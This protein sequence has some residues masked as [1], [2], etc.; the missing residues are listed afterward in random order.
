MQAQPKVRFFITHRLNI[1]G[2]MFKI[3]SRTLMV[4]LLA[5]S[6][7]APVLAETNIHQAARIKPQD[8]TEA[9]IL[10]NKYNLE[11][12][13]VCAKNLADKD[14][15]ETLTKAQTNEFAYRQ[16][17]WNNNVELA[18]IKILRASPWAIAAAVFAAASMTA[19]EMLNTTVWQD[20]WSKKPQ[21][22][23]RLALQV[24]TA[25]CAVA[26]VGTGVFAASVLIAPADR[27]L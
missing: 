20:Y 17:E 11:R 23:K 8:H 24:A 18:Q 12:A 27:P 1:R 25:A 26:A 13:I 3:S 4:A 15:F 19:D 7:S 22:A 5:T 6:F 21:W 9:T 2:P 16:T 14:Q 10:L